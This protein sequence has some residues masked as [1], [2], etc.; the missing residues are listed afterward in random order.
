VKLLAEV[1]DGENSP[2]VSSPKKSPAKLKGNCTRKPDFPLDDQQPS[3]SE[4][5]TSQSDDNE[6]NYNAHVDS[7][8]DVSDNELSL[9]DESGS[10][11]ILSTSKK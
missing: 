6:N 11:Y 8:S 2:T 1:S 10:E 9:E 3:L 4:T 5:V 7:S